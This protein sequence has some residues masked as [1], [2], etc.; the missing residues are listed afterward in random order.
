MAP[1]LVSIGDQQ[2]DSRMHGDASGPTT[3]C[4]GGLTH[5]ILRNTLFV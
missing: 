1:F 2:A 5:P 3:R 4:F